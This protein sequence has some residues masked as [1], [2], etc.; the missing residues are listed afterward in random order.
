MADGKSRTKL[1]L[2]IVFIAVGMIVPAGCCWF[3]VKFFSYGGGRH[4]DARAQL[5]TFEDGCKTYMMRHEGQPPPTLE[6]LVAP[7]DGTKPLV[8]G[9]LPALQCL[10]PGASYEYEPTHVDAKGQLDPMVTVKLPDEKV[11]YN[12]RRKG[13]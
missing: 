10:I 12:P 5:Q 9:G 8:E 3:D 6:Y 7:N 1:W 13:R 11:L 2:A 4:D